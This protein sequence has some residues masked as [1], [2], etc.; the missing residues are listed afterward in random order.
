[1]LFFAHAL[2]RTHGAVSLVMRIDTQY[3]KT[4]GFIHSDRMDSDYE[5]W[6]E[7]KNFNNVFIINIM[8]PYLYMVPFPVKS[9]IIKT[10]KII[11]NKIIMNQSFLLSHY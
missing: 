6:Y 10:V 11:N 3:C 5:T 2:P 7:K 1:M 4:H 8:N 9:I